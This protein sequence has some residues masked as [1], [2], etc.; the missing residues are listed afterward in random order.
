MFARWSCIVFAVAAT[1]CGGDDGADGEPATDACTPPS[2]LV[3]GQCVEPGGD[4][5]CP[6][7][8]LALEDG[9]CQP[10]GMTPSMC[11]DGFVHDGNR[12]CE[13][14]LPAD[15]CPT[16]LMALPG[17]TECRPVMDC[18]SG[19]WGAIAVDTATQYVDQVFTGASDGSASAPWTTIGEAVAAASAGGLVAVAAGSYLEDVIIEDKP[20]R[21]HGVCP[22]AVE[23]VGTGVETAALHILSGADGSE[24]MGLAIRGSDMGLFQAGSERVALERLWVHDNAT[25]GIK[26]RNDF[27]ATSV[28]IAGSLIEANGEL[29]VQVGGVVATIETTVVRGTLLDAQGEFG[30]GIVIQENLDDGMPSQGTVRGCVAEQNQ[31]RG[32]MVFNSQAAVETTV[33]RRNHSVGFYV[34]AS[35][36]IVET[37]VVRSTQLTAQGFDGRG[38]IIQTHRSTNAPSVATLR[39]VLVEDSREIGIHIRGS[40]AT[41]EAVVVDGVQPNAYDEYGRGLCIESLLSTGAPSTVTV[42]GAVVENSGKYGVYMLG[43]QLTTAAFLDSVLQDNKGAGLFV[44]GADV[45][46]EHSL[47]TRTMPTASGLYGDG[48][49]AMYNFLTSTPTTVVAT[50]DQID[51]SERAGISNFGAFVAIGDTA[52]RCAAF[53]LSGE[54]AQAQGFA[55]EDRG[56]TSCG[57]PEADGV[58]KVQSVGLEP[59]DRLEPVQ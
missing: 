9:S 47:I 40:E 49:L 7:G 44:A 39:S 37:S 54:H 2:E 4:E 38:F 19:K 10:A 42:R 33:V 34:E 12:R 18:G 24:V 14:I 13:S 32:I 51:D 53:G 25:Q 30:N 58:C 1:A 31:G 11:G 57:C 41:L 28:T 56:N 52:I 3:A 23:L 48:L 8:T 26:V 46:L 17:E 35:Q 50:A 36:V 6:A 27:G 55:F 43:A 16:G 45:T 59:P 15:A 20:V 5:G 29:G 21:V 22:A